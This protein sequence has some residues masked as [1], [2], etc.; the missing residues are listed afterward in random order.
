[1]SMDPWEYEQEA[2]M[3]AFIEESLKNISEDNVRSYLGT[4]GDAIEERVRECLR[5]AKELLDLNHYGPALTL[6]A[7]A[8]E[9]VIRFLL[10]RP[11][12][13]GAFLSDEWAE[14][15]AKRIAT[16]RSAEDRELLPAI[17]RQWGVDITSIKLSG[18]IGLWETIHDLWKKRNNFVHFGEIITEPV[19]I[20]GIECVNVILNKVVYPISMKLG[21][22]LETTGKWCEI[23]RKTDYGS[24]STSFKPKNPLNM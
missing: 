16:G 23:H 17:L 22:T 24:Y 4:F 3:E 6:S 2:A 19:A 18:K 13:Q 12:V 11:L 10:L 5:Q 8:I 20:S 7:T 1:M 9:I 21:F 15:L 14:I